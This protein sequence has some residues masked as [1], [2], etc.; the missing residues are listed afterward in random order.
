MSLS[1]QGGGCPFGFGSADTATGTAASTSHSAE[2]RA[3]NHHGYEPFQM[4]DPFP[5]YAALRAEEPVMYDERIGYWVV[6]RYDDVKAVFDDWETF[7]SENAQAP[8]RQRGPEAAQIM[9]DGGFTAYSGLSARIPPEHTRIRGIVQKAF[10]P[11]RFKVLEPFI[12]ANVAERLDAMLARGTD[13]GAG[14]G[15]IVRDLAYE[16]PTITILTLIGE[17]LAR[18]DDYKRWSDSRAA[19]TWGDLTDEEQ[20]PHAHNLVEYWQACIALVE[21]AHGEGGDNLVADLVKAQQDGAEISDHEIAS[22]CYSLLFAGHET[23]TT[24]I[25]NALRLLAA[26]SATWRQLVED[27]KKIPAA[28]DEVLRYS[29]SIVAWRRKALRDAEVGGVKIPAGAGIL[30]V[31][32]SANRDESKFEDPEVF[33]IARPNAREHLSFGFGIHYCLGNMLAKLQAK[34]ALEEATAKIP[35]L[36]V[37][38]PESIE[39]RENLSFRV[40]LAVRVSW[41]D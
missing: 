3:A 16:V 11:R 23:T 1:T 28:I 26:D 21:K 19:M 31:M 13:T 4:K 40:P 30:L 38:D 10:T 37:D 25:S 17:D 15:E 9:D 39:F 29:G 27:P 18:L 5:A 6:T 22:V 14:H 34:I 7:S 12:R 24:L 8:V 35:H 32:G 2:L 33:D 36:R 41:E 20:I